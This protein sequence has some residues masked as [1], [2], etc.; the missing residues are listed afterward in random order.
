MT[1]KRLITI[2]VAL[3][4]FVGILV[5]LVIVLAPK[6]AK[7]QPTNPTVASSCPASTPAP[8]NSVFASAIA[9]QAGDSFFLNQSNFEIKSINHPADCWFIVHIVLNNGA[10]P[11]TVLFEQQADGSISLVA[12]PGTSF[13]A[14]VLKTKGVPTSVQGQLVTYE[15]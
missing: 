14:S 11:S 6:P 4:A 2:S 9:N 5:V 10:G 15:N 8:S 3:I 7:P 12:G 13:S 1:R